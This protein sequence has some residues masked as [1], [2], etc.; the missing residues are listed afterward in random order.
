MTS[1]VAVHQD[2]SRL[3]VLVNE[4]ALVHRYAIGIV[5]TR[6]LEH[7]HGPTAVSPELEWAHSP[8]A[9]QFIPQPIFVGEAFDARR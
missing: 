7:E 4:A 3:D 6:V 8:C 2:I 1:G 5:D 9:I